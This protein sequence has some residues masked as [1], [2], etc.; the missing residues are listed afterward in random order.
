MTATGAMALEILYKVA[1]LEF[2][3]ALIKRLAEIV[4]PKLSG[5]ELHEVIEISR[6]LGDY[7]NDLLCNEASHNDP[8]FF[9]RA[10]YSVAEQIYPTVATLHEMT[11][12]AAGEL[13]DEDRYHQFD[14]D[15]MVIDA[16]DH[17]RA[18]P[19]VRSLTGK[20]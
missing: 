19:G 14:Y 11:F 17:D 4:V 10:F 18:H 15:A 16:V 2:N 3:A 9:G 7:E 20:C 1:E 13:R 8:F 12:D 6:S 5:A